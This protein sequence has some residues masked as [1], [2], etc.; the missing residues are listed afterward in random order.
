MSGFPERMLDPGLPGPVRGRNHQVVHHVGEPPAAGEGPASANR[1]LSQRPPM[2][3]SQPVA[4]VFNSTLHQG[5]LDNEGLE[6]QPVT[7]AKE[8]PG[9]TT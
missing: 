5:R 9:G 4:M 7:F 8:F 6:A 3:D 1:A 2:S